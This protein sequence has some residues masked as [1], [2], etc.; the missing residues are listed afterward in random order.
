[1][2]S[3]AE[4]EVGRLYIN[5]QGG[6]EFRVALQEM[7]H[8]QPPT[9]VITDNSTAEGIVNNCVKQH[10][11]HAV[12]MIFYWMQDHIKQG[13]YLVVWKPGDDNLADYSTKHFPLPTTRKYTELSW[14]KKNQV[15]YSPAYGYQ[16]PRTLQ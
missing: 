14:S 7:G 11:T 13:H 9:I 3:T 15:Q 2:E 10:R 5:C 8:P 4:A 6:E 12:G 16:T 1:M